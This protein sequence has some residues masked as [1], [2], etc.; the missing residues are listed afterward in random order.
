LC[1]TIAGK[2]GASFLF[3]NRFLKLYY[4]LLVGFE[5]GFD[6]LQNHLGFVFQSQLA[7]LDPSLCKLKP[8]GECPCGSLDLPK[9]PFTVKNR[10]A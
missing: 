10:E 1:L 8:L 9:D 6:A 5:I 3:G 2:N 7:S 4:E